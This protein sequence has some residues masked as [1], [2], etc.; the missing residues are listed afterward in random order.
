MKPQRVTR[1]VADVNKRLVGPIGVALGADAW[2]LADQSRVPRETIDA[3][4]SAPGGSN[5]IGSSG[6]SIGSVVRGRGGDGAMNSLRDSIWLK[7]AAGVGGVTLVGLLAYRAWRAPPGRCCA[8]TCCRIN[9]SID[10]ENPKVVH[11]MDT[12]DLGNESAFCRCWRSKK[13]PYCDGTHNKHNET[14]GDNVG[15][16]VIT[17]KKSS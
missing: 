8:K 11:A 6:D 16:L 17:V 7:I 14:T 1:D 12:S 2:A 3:R 5:S 15:P 4:P 10:K 13:F 9:P